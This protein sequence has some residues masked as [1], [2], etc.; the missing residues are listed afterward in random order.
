MKSC[1][2]ILAGLSTIALAADFVVQVGP[3]SSFIFDPPQVTGAA[4]GD[5]IVF[6]LYVPSFFIV[7]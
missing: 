2:Y 3:S 7:A 4:N 1:A 5:V 6:V